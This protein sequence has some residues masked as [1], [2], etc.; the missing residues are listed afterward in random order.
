VSDATAAPGPAHEPSAAL[1]GR[2]AAV[3]QQLATALDQLAA[4]HDK[5]DTIGAVA[6]RLAVVVDDLAPL[7]A[8]L[9]G[10]KAGA[11]LRVLT[12]RT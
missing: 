7:A 9:A 4:A 6:V 3:E 5:L 10:G 12:A 2:L 1:V 11:L 8:Q